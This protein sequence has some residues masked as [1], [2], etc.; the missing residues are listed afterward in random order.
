M[1]MALVK[2][3]DT[4]VYLYLKRQK[5]NVNTIDSLKN[6]WSLTSGVP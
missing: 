3:G 1:P 6:F 4:F 2:N 5:Q